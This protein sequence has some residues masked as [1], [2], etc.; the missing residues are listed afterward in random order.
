MPKGVASALKAVRDDVRWLEDLFPHNARDT[1]WLA[2]AGTNG[3]LVISRDKKIRTR[4]A[5]IQAIRDHRVGCFCLIQKQGLSGWP[6]LKRNAASVAQGAC[7][8]AC[9]QGTA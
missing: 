8:P 6:D 5:E 9:F 3:W 4:P 1:H 7:P 2:A